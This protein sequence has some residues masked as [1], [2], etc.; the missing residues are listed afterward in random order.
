[1][2][3]PKSLDE[4]KR[5]ASKKAYGDLIG[6]SDPFSAVAWMRTLPKE[7]QEAVNDVIAYVYHHEVKPP[8]L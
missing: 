4:A 3:Q 7:W 6:A 1:M 2:S 5:M 8:W